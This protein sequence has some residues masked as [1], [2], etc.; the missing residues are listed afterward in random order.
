V[1]ENDVFARPGETFDYTYLSLGVGVQS[2]ALLVL[3]AAGEAPRPE[4][5]VFADTGDEP[6]WVYDYLK[7]L[8]AW[9]P[10]P[11]HVAQKGVLSEWVID[12][13]KQ[14]ERFVTVPLYTLGEGGEREGMLRRQCSREFKIEPIEKKVRELL[15]YEPRRRIRERVCCMMGIS[16]DELRRMRPSRTRW[17]TNRYP[18]VELGID[19][20]ACKRIVLEAGLPEPKRSACVYCPYHSDRYWAWMRDEHPAEFARAVVFDEAVRNMTMA[21]L[22]RPAFVHRSCV[23]LAVAELDTG[24]PDQGDLFTDECEG[25]CGV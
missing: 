6:S 13:Q 17:V 16:V 22:E 18:L 7:V 3:A 23:P 1:R 5:A 21:G 15:G 24:D 2:T 20:E 19:R 8:Q 25:I 4:A 11:I 10:I 14:G 12:R 9:S